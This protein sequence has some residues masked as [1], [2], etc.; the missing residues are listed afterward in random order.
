MKVCIL[1]TSVS[2]KA[3]GLFTSVRRLNQSL[4][5]LPGT[6][7]EVLG[8]E[9]EW[10]RADLPEWNPLLPRCFPG[11]WP[12]AFGYSPALN[13][14]LL[15]SDYDL[16]HQHGL[17][18]FVSVAASRWHERTGRP[19]LISPHGMLDSWALAN[20]K[21]KKRIA[22]WVFENKN[23]RSAACL[24]ALCEAEAKAIR[25]F[26]LKNPICI[27]PNGIDLPVFGNAETLK[28]EILKSDG[29]KVLLYLG[30]IH[31][32]KGLVN[33]LRAWSQAQSSRHSTLDTRHS[34]WLL[35]IAGWDQGGHEKELK[36]LATALEIP[37]MDV[38]GKAETLK[39]EMLKGESASTQEREA[40]LGISAFQ[41]SS[42]LFL[43]P[44]FGAD[45]AAC[46]RSCDAFVLPSF[47][48]GLPMVVLEAW[49]HGRPVLMTPQCNLPEGFAGNA[50]LRIEPETDSIGAG[51]RSL[52]EMSAG[53]RRE[54]GAR[55]R[56]L[57]ARRFAWPG[58]AR[59]MRT[60]YEWMLGG[61]AKPE[62][63]QTKR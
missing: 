22:A 26:G 12:A 54:M 13:N 47:S 44:Q 56:S 5:I 11:K 6:R 14:H 37:W 17:W 49:A 40:D 27:I 63:V 20:S 9:D 2:R 43:G 36:Q 50:A 21:W 59:E 29:R 4:A 3:G 46:Y 61:G 35:A 42:V 62:C 51:L 24:H 23:I 58:I 41:R 25:A 55:G 16:V 15:Q 19:H 8:V 34:D 7:I 57:A 38:R 18:Q 48:E 10:T 60:V 53:E 33:L 32:K 30:R 45:K 1:T 31:P 39:T 52:F 28:S